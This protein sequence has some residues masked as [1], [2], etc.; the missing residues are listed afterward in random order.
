MPRDFS[1][2]I[3]IASPKRKKWRNQWKCKTQSLDTELNNYNCMFNEECI[4]ISTIREKV[5][6]EMAPLLKRRLKVKRRGCGS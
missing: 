2:P 4:K 1:Q 5:K 6:K 3:H